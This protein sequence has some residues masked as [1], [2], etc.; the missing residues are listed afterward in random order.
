MGV[1]LSRALKEVAAGRRAQVIGH[2]HERGRRAFLLQQF[3][4]RQCLLGGLN[5]QAIV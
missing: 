5:A 2:Q 4:R 3:E 1:E